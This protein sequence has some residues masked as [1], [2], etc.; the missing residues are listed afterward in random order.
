[1]SLAQRPAERYGA[2]VACTY[3]HMDAWVAGPKLRPLPQPAVLAARSETATMMALTSPSAHPY[4][5]RQPDSGRAAE[6][7]RP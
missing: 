2:H 3:V 5:Q 6:M 1:M 7:A 4:T